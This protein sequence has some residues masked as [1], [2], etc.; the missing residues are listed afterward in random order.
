MKTKI[1]LLYKSAIV[2]PEISTCAIS[3]GLAATLSAEMLRLG[4]IPSK[5]LLETLSSTSEA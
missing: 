2:L 1:S 4:F 3:E 5:D